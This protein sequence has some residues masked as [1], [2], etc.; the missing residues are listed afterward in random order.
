[1]GWGQAKGPGTSGPDPI[2]PKP[3]PVPMTVVTTRSVP[4]SCEVC[5][6]RGVRTLNPEDPD[7]WGPCDACE[8]RGWL[9]VTETTTTRLA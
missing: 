4:V 5:K 1:M 2:Y 6:G 9:R 8:S 7:D 3:A